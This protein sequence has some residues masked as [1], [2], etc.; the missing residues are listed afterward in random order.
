MEE[1]K[2]E[3]NEESVDVDKI[4]EEVQK[5]QEEKALKMKEEIKD[6]VKKELTTE[7]KLA[8]IEKQLEQERKDKQALQERLEETSRRIDDLPAQR[9]GLVNNQNPLT[10]PQ[11]REP[12]DEDIIKAAEE[13]FKHND[14]VAVH[15]KLLGV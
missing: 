3:E 7:Q 15:K 9:K 5:E 12:T 6:S 10:T 1:N 11:R 14:P 8:E 2:T 13:A 4:A